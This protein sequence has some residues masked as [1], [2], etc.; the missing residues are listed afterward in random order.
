MENKVNLKL[1]LFIFSIAIWSC[2]FDYKLALNSATREGK[3]VAKKS[4]ILNQGK[5]PPLPLQPF[6]IWF[7]LMIRLKLLEMI[8]SWR[9]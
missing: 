9:N 5:L 3:Y 1:T 4:T 6:N 8:R 2:E 7:F